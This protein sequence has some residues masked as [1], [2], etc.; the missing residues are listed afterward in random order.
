MVSKHA[1][2]LPFALDLV[3]KFLKGRA[4]G[5]LMRESSPRIIEALLH[6]ASHPNDL[7]GWPGGRFSKL[8]VAPRVN[9]LL[10]YSTACLCTSRNGP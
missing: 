4:G 7:M 6:R 2:T 5:V 1:L 10:D 8:C 3:P 9:K